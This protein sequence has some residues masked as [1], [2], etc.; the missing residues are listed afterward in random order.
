MSLNSCLCIIVALLI[1][2]FLLVLAGKDKSAGD[3]IDYL[4]SAGLGEDKFHNCKFKK[5]TSVYLDKLVERNLGIMSPTVEFLNELVNS[6]FDSVTLSIL[7]EKKRILENKYRNI[8]NIED[9]YEVLSYIVD[10][11]ELDKLMKINDCSYGVEI[12]LL[13]TLV[14]N[15]DDEILSFPF[16]NKKTLKSFLE[17]EIRNNP[18][19]SYEDKIKYIKETKEKYKYIPLITSIIKSLSNLRF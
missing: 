11:E 3:G 7:E 14:F 19:K 9:L 18:L 17:N 6:D 16:H 15:H 2:L 5:D 12:N 13:T 10:K 8:K 4:I 1:T